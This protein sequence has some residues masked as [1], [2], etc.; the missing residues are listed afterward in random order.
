M[1]PAKPPKGVSELTKRLLFGSANHCAF[2]EC[3]APLVLL[4]GRILSVNA[5]VAHIRSPE[6]GGPRHVAEYSSVHAF[7]NLLLLCSSHHHLI[8]QHPEEFPVSVLERWKGDQVA[9]IGQPVPYELLAALRRQVAELS[10]VSESQDSNE[11]SLS[12]WGLRL[13]RAS[14]TESGSFWIE[15]AIDG[16]SVSSGEN[17]GY[18]GVDL[19]W[20]RSRRELDSDYSLSEAGLEFDVSKSTGV[21]VYVFEDDDLKDGEYDYAVWLTDEKE[22][23]RSLMDLIRSS[24]TLPTRLRG[25]MTFVTYEGISESFYGRWISPLDIPSW[26]NLIKENWDSIVTYL[27]SN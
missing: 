14:S 13:V 11:G 6:P 27:K 21:S 22:L 16:V 15:P 3:S 20:L 23:H 2:P 19:N 17:P 7:E 1:S 12:G 4:H 18:F 24:R 26:S 10:E 9:Q 8:D 5:E 25:F